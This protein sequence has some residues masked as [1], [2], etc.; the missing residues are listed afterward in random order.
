[1]PDR[2]PL[3]RSAI[4]HGLPCPR[5]VPWELVAAHAKQAKLN[6]DQTLERLAERGGLDP[7]E[8]WCVVHGKPWRERPTI[9]DALA[10]LAEVAP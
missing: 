4:P 5:S 3:L 7:R 6:H 9:E 8:L 1:M 2:F 10:W